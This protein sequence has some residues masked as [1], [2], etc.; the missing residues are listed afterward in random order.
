MAGWTRTG[1]V[2]ALV[3]PGLRSGGPSERASCPLQPLDKPFFLARTRHRC[4]HT[5]HHVGKSLA[6]R[7]C[8]PDRREDGPPTR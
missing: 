3:W 2:G 7:V 6:V 8:V 4:P 1:R 5:R